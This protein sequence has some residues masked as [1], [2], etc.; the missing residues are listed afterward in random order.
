MSSFILSKEDG[1]PRGPSSLLPKLKNKTFP[2][3]S[4]LGILFFLVQL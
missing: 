2:F 1:R 4:P 3:F